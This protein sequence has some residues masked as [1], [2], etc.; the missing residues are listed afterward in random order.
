MIFF[1][2]ILKIIRFYHFDSDPRIPPFY[3]MLGRN[4]GSLLYGDVS[5][6]AKQAFKGLKNATA[7]ILNSITNFPV[8]EKNIC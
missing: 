6:M 5:M 8:L 7:K 1:G 2:E 3:Y 4:L